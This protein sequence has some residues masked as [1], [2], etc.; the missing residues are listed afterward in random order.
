MARKILLTL[1]ILILTAYALPAEEHG[2]FGIGVTPFHGRMVNIY[3]GDYF[4][5]VAPPEVS[6]LIW[7]GS[8]LSVRPHLGFF[9]ASAKSH[10]YY[11]PYSTGSEK[12]NYVGGLVAG[13]SIYGHFGDGPTYPFVGGDLTLA[14]LGMTNERPVVEVMFSVQ[15]GAE[16]FFS[17]HFS[18]GGMGGLMLGFGDEDGKI[19][20]PIPNTDFAVG[21]E[22]SLWVGVYY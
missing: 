7:S 19:F 20:M 12:N 9:L 2:S 16:H 22:T 18:V 13:T 4:V 15:T 10:S 21:F 8:G 5:S 14:Q 1:L 3:L 11:Y 17:P 6:F